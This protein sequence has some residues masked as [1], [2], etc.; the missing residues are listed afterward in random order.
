MRQNGHGRFNAQDVGRVVQ[1]GQIRNVFQF[2]NDFLGGHDGFGKLAAVH[3]AVPYGGN[4]VHIGDDAVFFV[5]QRTDDQ[6]DGVGVVFA[7]LPPFKSFF[8][9]AFVRNKRARQ[10]DAFHSAGGQAAFLL[11]VIDAVFDRRAA[12]IQ[13][14]NNH[15]K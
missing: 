12:A 9:R 6:V 4:H 11:P 14:Q 8:P 1:R 15:S 7:V 13:K 5:G 10:A 3:D 2:V